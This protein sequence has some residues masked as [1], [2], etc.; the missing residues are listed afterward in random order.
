MV[1][2][3][4][5]GE[6]GEW[7]AMASPLHWNQSRVLFS[8]S[9]VHSAAFAVHLLCARHCGAYRQASLISGMRGPRR[10]AL[11]DNVNG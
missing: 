1:T 9:E 4:G 10:H 7:A 11:D 3:G 2:P 8:V 6:V 5:G